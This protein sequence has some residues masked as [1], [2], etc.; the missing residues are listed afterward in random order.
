[1]V[2]ELL[3]N[4]PGI[5]QTYRFLFS[6]CT[7]ILHGPGD[8]MLQC[9]CCCKWPIWIAKHLACQQNKIGL[10]G[11]NDVVSLLWRGDKPYC[12]SRNRRL[13]ANAL[14]EAGLIAGTGGYGRAC[15]IA[16]GAYVDKV[17]TSLP[18]ESRKSNRFLYC[19]SHAFKVKSVAG[20]KPVRGGEA[21]H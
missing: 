12:G 21:H 1:M 2:E 16:T 19:P 11:A 17:H 5:R 13:P 4:S 6:R 7:H 3:T 9:L 20:L 18:Q 10:P 15:K 8:V 14:C